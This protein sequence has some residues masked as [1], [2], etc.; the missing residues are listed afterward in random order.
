MSIDI[1]KYLVPKHTKEKPLTFSVGI[2]LWFLLVFSY[3]LFV[4]D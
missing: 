1:R 4:V 2:I 3:L